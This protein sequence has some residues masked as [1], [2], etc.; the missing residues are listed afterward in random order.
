L[1]FLILRLAT[2]ETG[3][4]TANTNS[5]AGE[6]NFKFETVS[7]F[8]P[9]RYQLQC[10]A[11]T[12]NDGVLCLDCDSR[13]AVGPVTTIRGAFWTQLSRLQSL[14]ALSARNEWSF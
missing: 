9:T 2:D 8:L 7:S 12:G 5:L 10:T 1:H 13:R 11:S 6:A 4:V 14:A 3:D